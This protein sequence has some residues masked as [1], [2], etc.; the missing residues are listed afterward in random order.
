LAL[1]S[2]AKRERFLVEEKGNR[3][4]G[5]GTVKGEEDGFDTVI[6]FGFGM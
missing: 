1:T 2:E 6:G 4:E 3:I 5:V